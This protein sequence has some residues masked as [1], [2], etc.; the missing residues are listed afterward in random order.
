MTGV[1]TCALPISENVIRQAGYFDANKVS[2]LV[3]KC[4][5]NDG[6]LQSERENMALVGILSTQLVD[7]MFI[8]NFPAYPIQEPEDVKIFGTS[9]NDN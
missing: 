5:L 7:D 2:R 1:Q 3:S 8:Q 4:R 6:N 9:Q